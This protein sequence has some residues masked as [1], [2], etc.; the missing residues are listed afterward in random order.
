MLP[1][2]AFK[3]DQSLSRDL[4]R[5]TRGQFAGEDGLRPEQVPDVLLGERLHNE[6]SAWNLPDKT[7]I[8]QRQQTFSHWSVAHTYCLGDALHPKELTGANC[9]GHD[10]LA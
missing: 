3:H 6:S 4:L 9:P 8:A 5:R 2:Q 10:E 7:L 1:D